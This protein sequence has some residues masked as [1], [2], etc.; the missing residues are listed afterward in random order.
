MRPGFGQ[1]EAARR[2][3]KPECLPPLA[4]WRD[5]P[6][7]LGRVLSLVAAL[8]LSCA[9]TDAH[10]YARP[11]QAETAR[12]GFAAAAHDAHRAQ[13][14]VTTDAASENSP[15][16]AEASDGRRFYAKARY[17]G[18]GRGGFI[19]VDPW[20]GDQTNPLS[21]N[22]YLY[23]FGNPGSYVDP[24]GRCAG[25]LIIPCAAA[26]A[27][28]GTWAIDYARARWFG[29]PQ[30]QA[31][32][33]A[34]ATASTAYALETTGTA[35]AATLL[36]AQTGGAATPLAV[37]LLQG[38]RTGLNVAL[39]QNAP[40][41]AAAADDLAYTVAGFSGANTP[42]L[43]APLALGGAQAIDAIVDA[44]RPTIRY[45]DE[46]PRVVWQSDV[47]AA[48]RPPI[49]RDRVEIAEG[50]GGAPIATV[51]ASDAVRR[52]PERGTPEGDSWRYDR[53]VSGGGQRS[54][55]DWYRISRGGRSGGDN[56]RQIQRGLGE[57]DFDTEVQFG[58][59]YADAAGSGEIHQIGGR[60]K[61]G[62]PIMRERRAI[63]EIVNSR[64]YQG[65][66]IYFWDKNEPAPGPIANPHLSSIWGPVNG[67][68]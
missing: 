45:G 48:A 36:I 4:R 66:T 41:V 8:L 62:D 32:P 46:A 42:P 33:A 52:K 20:D 10:S 34:V 23:A 37:G 15:A 6:R 17:Y 50:K 61:R 51:P 18:G 49:Q 58:G 57:L 59:R 24:D 27:T 30:E 55:E 63:L 25:P 11:L 38:G 65:Q 2:R 19:S 44:A 3:L 26:I 60:N 29:T 31:S 53:Y 7:M 5:T 54:F 14:R 43:T 1:V 47:P 12:Q 16:A 13:A 35:A 56:H 9:S 64:E 40:R 21:Y 67:D 22:K 68:E 39:M 28:A